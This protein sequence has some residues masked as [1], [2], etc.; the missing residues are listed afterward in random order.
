MTRLNLEM[1]PH[2]YEEL[3]KQAK[4]EGKTISALV[5]DLVNVHLTET[6]G[7]RLRATAIEGDKD[8]VGE[9]GSAERSGSG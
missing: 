1:R 9:H 2:Q 3:R 4:M 6:Q 7:E 8:D 5:R